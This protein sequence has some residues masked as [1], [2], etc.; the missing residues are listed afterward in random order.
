MYKIIIEQ[1]HPDKIYPEVIDGEF[2]S[3]SYAIAMMETILKYFKNTSV[4]IS[5]IKED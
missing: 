4:S 1:K 2:E 3:I 5:C